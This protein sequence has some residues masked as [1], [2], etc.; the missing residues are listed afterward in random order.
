MCNI[1]LLESFLSSGKQSDAWKALKLVF[2]RG[3]VP[4]HI[5]AD[6]ARELF[7]EGNLMKSMCARAGTRLT[8]VE[9]EVHEHNLAVCKIN[10]L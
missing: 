4:N 8:A 9:K 1:K 10:E 6:L 5:V 3:G 2:E 7:E